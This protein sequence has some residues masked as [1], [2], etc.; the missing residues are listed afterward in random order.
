MYGFFHYTK[1]LPDGLSIEGETV[2]IGQE[3]IE[4]LIDSTFINSLGEKVSQQEIFNKIFQMIDNAQDYILIDMFLVGG[5][6]NAY[7]HLADEL[8]DK[9]IQK[10]K[11]NPDIKINF[12]TDKYNIVYSDENLVPQFK[13]LQEANIPI[14][15]TDVNKLRD[16]NVAYSSVW[17]LAF[18]WIDAP[19]SGRYKNP[20]GEYPE[21]I[22]I[23]HLL[24]LFNFKANH[25][26]IVMTDNGDDI[27][28]LITSAN[29]HDP[30]SEHSNIGLYFVSQN[31]QDIY[32]S[33][34]AVAEFSRPNTVDSASS[35]VFFL[36][37]DKKY[38]DAAQ[39]NN[40]TATSTI[41]LQLQILTEGKIKKSILQGINSTKKGDEIKLAI[42]YLSDRKVIESLL[43]ASE[44]EV[45]IKIILDPNKDA[46]GIEKNGI[47]NRQVAN[48]LTELSENKIAIRWY[49]TQGEQFHT[50]LL[51]IH[52]QD[53]AN[54][55]NLGSANFTKRNLDDFN[56]ETN[57]QLTGPTSSSPFIKANELF[58]SAW[59]NK[60]NN[61]YT[62]DYEKYKDD[63]KLKF[64][65]YRFQE[66][67]GMSTF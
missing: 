24:E 42:F 57:V 2:T 56:L 22:S 4:L 18:Q 33:E 66:W 36:D 62:A 64:W 1:A 58:D 6:K 20:F 52:K 38:F 19:K 21:K 55:I 11:E 53:G 12:I 47:P 43:E 29:P 65:I 63:S 48:E 13:R 51:L 9:L 41:S 45:D 39:E 37:I 60:N 44:R 49:D 31:W 25:R 32:K 16:S 23:V 7:R 5:A 3:D 46:F 17:R 27:S 26:K 59:E 34:K 54:V 28:T 40:N 8:T 61:T 50:K 35:T 10:K 14:I 30:S 67:S 15:F